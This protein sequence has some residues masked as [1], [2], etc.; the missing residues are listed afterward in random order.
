VIQLPKY[1]GARVILCPERNG[2]TWQTGPVQIFLQKVVTHRGQ[3]L[4]SYG[5]DIEEELLELPSEGEFKEVTDAVE[6]GRE[7][8]LRKISEA[9]PGNK[10]VVEICESIKKVYQEVVTTVAVRIKGGGRKGHSRL[11]GRSLLA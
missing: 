2:E 4:S 1:N 6:W 8:A 7:R 10:I 5:R 9:V 11:V 3:K